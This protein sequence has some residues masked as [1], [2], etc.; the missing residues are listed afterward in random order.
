MLDWAHLHV[1]IV[2][3]PIV[4]TFLAMIP[5]LWGF[6]KKDISTQ[7]IG[8]VVL[9]ISLF[10]IPVATTSGEN[11][12]HAF[13]RGTISAQLDDAGATALKVHA[14]TADAVAVFWYVIL[15]L[16]ITQLIL[17]KRDYSWKNK[18]FIIT[19]VLN[20]LLIIGLSYVGYLW[21]KIRHPEFRTE[22]SV[23]VPTTPVAE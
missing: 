14:E 8:L 3:L 15:L 22:A 6:Y 21:G 10:A 7:W 4:G 1:M 12:E 5:L 2:H 19:L 11:T 20:T 17:W 16:V 9:A 23:S 13:Y 18:L